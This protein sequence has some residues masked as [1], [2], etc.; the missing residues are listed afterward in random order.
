MAL[1]DQLQITIV[2]E[3]QYSTKDPGERHTPWCL[4]TKKKMKINGKVYLK[5]A[6]LDFR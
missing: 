6:I 3:E 4:E 2:Q 5:V 1:Y